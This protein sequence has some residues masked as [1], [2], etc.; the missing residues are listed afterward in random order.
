MGEFKPIETEEQFREVTKDLLTQEQVNGIINEKSAG[1]KKKYEGYMSP[2]E[3]STQ[4]ADMTKQIEELSASLKEEQA[5]VKQYETASVKSRVAH[6]VGLPYE[7][8]HKLS[9]DTEEEIR[10]DAESLKSII[11]KTRKPAPP[12]P[13]PDKASAGDAR[14]AAFKKTLEGLVKE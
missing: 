12:V 9:G 5:K 6:E 2:D 8:A 1:W 3:F 13:E 14:R 11:G 10:K 7:L 4:T